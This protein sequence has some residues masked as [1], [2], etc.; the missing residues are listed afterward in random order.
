MKLSA[1]HILIGTM[2][3]VI[4]VLSWALVFFARDEIR[5]AAG[6]RL[7]NIETPSGAGSKGGRAVVRV[8]AASQKA[9]G[10]ATRPLTAAETA[11]VTEVYGT[12]VN[13]QPLLEARGRYLAAM[14][15][16]G[17]RRATAAAAEAEFRR[18]QALYRDER[19]ASEQ[20][21]RN[22]EAR[23]RAEDAQAAAA[24]ANVEAQ[25]DTLRTAWGPTIAGWAS[26][27]GAAV[28][29]RLL[30]REAHLV[31]LAFPYGVPRAAVRSRFSVVPVI[32]AARPRPVRFVSDAPQVEGLL[33]GQ[34]FFYLVDGADLRV[35]S[36]VT[37]QVGTG[38]GTR[39]GVIVPAEAVV[40]HAG[41]PWVYLRAD[42]DTFARYSISTSREQAG[43]WFDS[44]GE[45]KEGDEVVVSGAQLLLSEELKFQIRNENED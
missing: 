32:G 1:T 5:P 44:G 10:I 14:A 43:G 3:L 41:K 16:A 33:P 6:P 31:Q 29:Q 8:S 22:A 11:D 21:L 39:R 24:Q 7:E 12:V 28:L 9:S 35:G 30:R 45:L 23:Y 36:R 2:A 26:R 18:T 34:T 17:A 37:A 38:S 4:A 20:A 13:I 15:E 40:W 25:Y 19:N 27:P 42:D